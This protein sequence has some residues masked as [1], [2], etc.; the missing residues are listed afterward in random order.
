[1]HPMFKN[2]NPR[3]QQQVNNTIRLVKAECPED[4]PE[5]AKLA[6]SKGFEVPDDLAPATG[7]D[8]LLKG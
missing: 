6:K 1:M 2:W 4:L 3:N 5:I 7:W 8:S